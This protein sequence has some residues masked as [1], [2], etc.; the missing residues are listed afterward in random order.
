MNKPNRFINLLS[1]TILFIK[2]YYFIDPVLW[3]LKMI[4]SFYQHHFLCSS[5]SVCFDPVEIHSAGQIL[6]MKYN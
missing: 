6:C 4:L 5:E 2:K 3:D 1:L